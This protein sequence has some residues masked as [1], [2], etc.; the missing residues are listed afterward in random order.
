MTMVGG[1]GS[2]ALVLGCRKRFKCDCWVCGT[3]VGSR[4]RAEVWGP[5]VCP[6]SQ[7]RGPTGQWAAKQHHRGP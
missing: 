1:S 3:R 7:G 6:L 4:L 5:E 2:A